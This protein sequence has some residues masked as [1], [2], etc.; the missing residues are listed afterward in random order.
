MTITA[1]FIPRVTGATTTGF[2]NTTPLSG[3]CHG[4]GS[5]CRPGDFTITVPYLN[6]R[7]DVQVPGPIES[8]NY[9]R[10]DGDWKTLMVTNDADGQTTPLQF[11][12][13]LLARR[14]VRAQMRPGGT[15]GGISQVANLVGYGNAAGGCQGRP[16]AANADYYAFAWSVPT[17]FVTCTHPPKSD[18][19]GPYLTYTDEISIGYELKTPDPFTLGNG[20]YRGSLVYT[21]G[22]GSQIDLGIGSYNQSAITL[23][24]ELTVKHELR[25]DFATHSDR[26]VLEPDGGWG[27]WLNHASLPT[28]LRRD[29][30]FQIWA[31]APLKMYLKCSE[32]MGNQC[33]MREPH[34]GHQVP[35][36]VAV[37][38][39][40]SIRY[41]GAPVEKLP[42]PVGEHQALDFRSIA[43]AA[44]R[45]ARMH[46]W[47][48]PAHIPA[49]LNHNGRQYSGDVTIVFDAQI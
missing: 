13:S 45:P 11:R 38:L 39:P 41:Q 43:V 44:G 15:P 10:V 19:W 32:P 16:G 21:T 18:D 33:S 14:Y 6:I 48:D 24:F 30:P 8:H 35:F 46:Y 20:L 31:S 7:R 17:G 5:Y 25:V 12:L 26:A 23:D 27:Q 28:S 29:H 49:M 22:H 36:G 4:N 9:Q 47:V 40:G 34:S 1:E 37:T 3:Y 42:L 2:V